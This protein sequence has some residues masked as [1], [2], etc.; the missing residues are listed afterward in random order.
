MNPVIPHRLI[1]ATR[2]AHKT[3][4]LAQ[5]LGSGFVVSDLTG[6]RNI[7]VVEET[8]ET[9]EENAVLKALS[10]SRSLPGLVV[11]D[12]S[13]LEVALLNGA[14]GVRSA[15]YAGEHAT[16]AENIARVLAELRQTNAPTAEW[17]ACFQCILVLAD[18]GK[19]V[20]TFHGTVRGVI[21]SKP[22]GTHGFGYD[23]IFVPEGYGQ[24][25]AELGDAV[26]NR[27]SHRAQ[28][29]ARLREHFVG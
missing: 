19:I 23:P 7:S 28:A 25:F 20:R 29:I 17:T 14:P 2:N 1:L 21:V 26:K 4:E 16:D 8:G 11:S 13:G 24:T 6:M 15:R 10:A 27:I 22:R 12:D 18:A 3:R 9:F 5:T